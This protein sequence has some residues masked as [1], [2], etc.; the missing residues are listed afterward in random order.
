MLNLLLEFIL[1]LAE[2]T[3]GKNIRYLHNCNFSF[4]PMHEK[5]KNT[6]ANTRGQG[7]TE[8]R[9]YQADSD[10]REKKKELKETV[11]RWGG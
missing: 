8:V 2:Q 4:N 1:L 3:I 10:T 6:F 5:K 11:V 7:C 9:D